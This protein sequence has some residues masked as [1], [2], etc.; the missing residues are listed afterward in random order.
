IANGG[1]PPVRDDLSRQIRKL[2]PSEREPS[3]GAR[4]QGSQAAQKEAFGNRIQEPL[5]A[6]SLQFFS[7]AFPSGKIAYSSMIKL[8]EY[9]NGFLNVGGRGGYYTTPPR[10]TFC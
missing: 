8:P 2:L 4:L 10:Y 1:I 6:Q 7:V 9:G 3:V 5:I